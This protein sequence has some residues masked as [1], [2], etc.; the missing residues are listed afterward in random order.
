[1]TEKYTPI[2]ASDLTADQIN[3]AL[4]VARR[5][6]RNFAHKDGEDAIPVPARTCRLLALT[7]I[8][9]NDRLLAGA[10][11]AANVEAASAPRK[12]NG[13]APAKGKAVKAPKAEQAP[14]GPTLTPEQ[15]KAFR[16]IEMMVNDKVVIT[17]RRLSER[18]GWGSHNTGARHIKNLIDLGYLKKVG[19][20]GV[21]ALTGL[22]P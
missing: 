21:I 10:V 13:K 16:M 3:E 12:P 9:L 22:Q 15:T 18:G 19:S 2:Q 17:S 5:Y 6:D 20:K 7:I 8:N 11:D 1:M 14:C 4:A